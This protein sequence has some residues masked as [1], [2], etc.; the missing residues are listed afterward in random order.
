M[1]L[2][3]SILLLEALLSIA[4]F[5]PQSLQLHMAYYYTLV[6]CHSLQLWLALSI[7]TL[8]NLCPCSYLNLWL[9]LFT[10]SLAFLATLYLW[11]V[12]NSGWLFNSLSYCSASFSSTYS[13]HFNSPNVSTNVEFV[14]GQE[15]QTVS[16]PPQF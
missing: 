9:S 1:G 4:L 6:G 7:L 14:K 16:Q 3:T 12:F 2:T 8:A 13:S 5:A 10:L 11:L 15:L